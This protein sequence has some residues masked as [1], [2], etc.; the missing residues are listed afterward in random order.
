MMKKINVSFDMTL[1]DE[2]ENKDIEKWLSFH[3]DITAHLDIPLPL[4]NMEL[5][6]GKPQF[7]IIM[8]RK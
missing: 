8:V 6:D 5:Y 7:L 3:L 4:A 2:A 1:P